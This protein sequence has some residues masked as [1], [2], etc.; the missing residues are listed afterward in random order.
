MLSPSRTPDA[1]GVT[2]GSLLMIESMTLDVNPPPVWRY[3]RSNPAK[4]AVAA[5]PL[6]A[7]VVFALGLNA[8]AEVFGE[9]SEVSN[10]PLK[11]RATSASTTDRPLALLC[12]L[13]PRS[14][15]TAMVP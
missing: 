8:Y 6:L 5:A 13:P 3:S 12:W 7:V 11:F 1:G 15:R 2:G 10:E 14:F 4:L 9:R